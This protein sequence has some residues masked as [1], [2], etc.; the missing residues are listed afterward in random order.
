MLAASEMPD[1][2]PDENCIERMTPLDALPK[3]W[4]DLANEYGGK[5]ALAMRADGY[6][7]VKELRELFVHRNWRRQEDW[8]AQ[9]P[10][11]LK[12]TVGKKVFRSCGPRQRSQSIGRLR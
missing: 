1:V 2:P 8:L 4:R 11:P 7:N 6:T 10:Y 12:I 5:I 3:E 9:I